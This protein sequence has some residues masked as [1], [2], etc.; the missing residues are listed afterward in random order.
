MERAAHYL[1][2]HPIVIWM[3]LYVVLWPPVYWAMNGFP[4]DRQ[5]SKHI[6]AFFCRHQWG[7][8]DTAGDGS[9][10]SLADWRQC[11]KCPLGQIRKH[12]E[13]RNTWYAPFF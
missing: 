7:E 10:E 3:V 4:V 2:V 13:T 1:A 11:R 12:G 9:I 6:R 8:W 5:L